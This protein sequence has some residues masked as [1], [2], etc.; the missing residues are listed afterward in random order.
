[1]P[2]RGIFI[3]WRLRMEFKIIN[4]V[5]EIAFKTEAMMAEITPTVEVECPRKMALI[6]SLHVDN[7]ELLP[8]FRI[9]MEEGNNTVTLKS[10]KIFNPGS[11]DYRMDLKLSRNGVDYQ[12]DSSAITVR[13]TCP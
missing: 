6:G 10:V 11:G 4:V 13:K 7:H 1:M 3:A 5:Y 9:S 12:K 8:S 2:E